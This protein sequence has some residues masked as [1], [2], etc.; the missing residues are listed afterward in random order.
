[1]KSVEKNGISR[2]VR[3]F[4]PSCSELSPVVVQSRTD[5]SLCKTIHQLSIVIIMSINNEFFSSQ[6]AFVE[7]QDRTLRPA[8]KQK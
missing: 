4:A 5:L 7:F 8:P 3:S 6:K 1:M 2:S